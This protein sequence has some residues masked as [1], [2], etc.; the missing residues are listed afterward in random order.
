MG[1]TIGASSGSS[2]A[3]SSSSSSSK[4]SN[5]SS[6][7][8][9]K[10]SSSPSSSSGSTST[11]ERAESVQVPESASGSGSPSETLSTDSADSDPSSSVQLTSAQEEAAEEVTGE[12]VSR[13]EDT[14]E[15]TE[16]GAETESTSAT[17]T[18]ESQ[19]IDNFSSPS[20]EL[21]PDEEVR[22]EEYR[23]LRTRLEEIDAVIDRNDATIEEAGGM[24]T[25]EAVAPG[26]LVMER[27]QVVE[28]IQGMHDDY[29][30][31][32]QDVDIAYEEV[33]QQRAFNEAL[34]TTNGALMQGE[35]LEALQ[36]FA[37]DELAEASQPFEAATDQLLAHIEDPVFQEFFRD[38]E[39]ARQ[40]D[41]VRDVS[42]YL[43]QTESGRAWIAE[44]NDGFVELSRTGQ[45][46]T[47]PS[48]FAE[49]RDRVSES[50]LQ[51]LD[52]D[53]GGLVGIDLIARP[54]GA[55]DRLASVASALNLPA[56]Q[57]E[58]LLHA[59]PE[60]DPEA[61]GAFAQS[62]GLTLEA[63][64]QLKEVFGT[65]ELLSQVN[66]AAGLVGTTSRGLVGL[67][68]LASRSVSSGKALRALRAGLD[69]VAATGKG[70]GGAAGVV[71]DVFDVLTLTH[72]VSRGELVD[73]GTTA[74]GMVGG[75]M[76]AS[77]SAPV[78]VTGGALVGL[79]MV[80]PAF[81]E[82]QDYLNF[83]DQAMRSVLGD[84]PNSTMRGWSLV[85]ANAINIQRLDSMRPEEVTLPDF[86]EHRLNNMPEGR[87][88]TFWE[89]IEE[90]YKREN[91]LF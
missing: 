40:Q 20:T 37:T 24:G 8:S 34:L 30:D 45:A 49:L 59:D 14:R 9:S 91:N 90:E 64:D 5:S 41:F 3:A 47:F 82:H 73:A 48:A 62:V 77:S 21:T 32:L 52:H 80:A 88:I 83:Q 7:S 86:F 25:H 56:E 71:G 43:P 69:V 50:E 33:Q 17:H 29:S 81:M 39:P 58:L 26:A 46:E 23:D 13:S 89:L 6:S 85:D 55:E 16:D 38:W 74:V 65:G 44:L 70:V 51:A 63:H 66:G 4:S 10:S 84:S 76:L 18:D 19:E 54:E 31:V 42:Q 53:L 1:T 35:E 68:E 61:L 67:A 87:S 22:M 28:E 57:R 12:P 79:S 11:L 15:T 36:S 27:L 2:S 75:A 72:Q 78:A 60:G